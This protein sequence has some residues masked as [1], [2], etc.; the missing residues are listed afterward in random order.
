MKRAILIFFSF[1]I[2]YSSY[3][4]VSKDTLLLHSPRKATIKSAIIP[5]WGQA[6]NKKYW[7]IPVIYAG[8]GALAYFIYFNNCK[9]LKYKTAYIQRVDND[10]T[11]ID[12]FD[13]SYP[14][15]CNQDKCT[16][17]GPDCPKYTSS[18]LKI[19]RDFYRRNRDLSVI[20]TAFLYTI[21]IIDATVDAHLYHFD[22]SDD[23]SLE[24]IPLFYKTNSNT[25]FAGINLILTF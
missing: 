8:F 23:L 4:Q 16:K 3:S 2:C 11:T 13:P 21:N 22:V 6:Y 15:Q 12:D 7:K 1:F 14:N 24:A 17:S 10:S 20:L 25:T 5:G 9:Y 18:N 19:L